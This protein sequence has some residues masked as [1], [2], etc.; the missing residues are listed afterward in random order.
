[1]NGIG[2]SANLISPSLA[3]TDGNTAATITIVTVVI[4]TVIITI[5]AIIAIITS[6]IVNT[7]ITVITSITAKHAFEV[8]Q[9]NPFFL[10]I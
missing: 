7:I 1:M 4:V 8:P 3:E 5:L 9:R 2:S 10:G 6:V